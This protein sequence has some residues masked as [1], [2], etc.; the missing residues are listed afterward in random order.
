MLG[1]NFEFARLL[2]E[3]G[4]NVLFADLTLRPE[5]EK[6]LAQYQSKPKAVFQKT[7]VSSWKDL[8][9]MF[10]TA[11]D[12][13]GQVDIVCPGAG[14]FEPPFSN[15]WIPPGTGKSRDSPSGDRYATMDINVTHPIRV[16]QMAISHF[17]AQSTSPSKTNPKTIIHIASIAGESASLMVPLYYASKHAIKAFIMSLGDMESLFGIRVAGVLPGIVKTPLWTEHPE[18]L[19]IVNEKSDEWI[20]PEDIAQVMLDLVVKDEINSQ[21]DGSGQNFPVGGGSCI[22]ILSQRRRAVTLANDPGPG[23][24]EGATVS[25]AGILYKEIVESLQPGWGSP[26]QTNGSH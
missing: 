6:V 12:A 20:M 23:E 2:L 9:Q 13:F 25:D 19:Q 14:V 7:D 21:K 24:S 16:T 18:K 3:G 10:K 26:S 15:F 8:D 22:E 17:L 11:I 1:I 4:C 5:S